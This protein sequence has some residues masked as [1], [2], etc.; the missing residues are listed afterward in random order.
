LHVYTPARPMLTREAT[1][2]ALGSYVATAGMQ[3]LGWMIGLL[4]VAVFIF[5][6]RDFQ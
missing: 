1:D 5:Q 6:R 2:A 4:A 3:T